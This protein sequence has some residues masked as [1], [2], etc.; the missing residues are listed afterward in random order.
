MVFLLSFF[1]LKISPKKRKNVRAREEAKN[2]K[3]KTTDFT[4]FTRLSPSY[5]LKKSYAIPVGQKIPAD[6]VVAV[7]A[8]VAVHF[9]LDQIS[10][11]M[12]RTAYA[13]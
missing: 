1:T 4:Y 7:D 8:P 6:H 5:L 11:L 3:R 13:L 10:Y 12:V 2:D 9:W